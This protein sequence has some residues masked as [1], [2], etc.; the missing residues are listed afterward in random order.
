MSPLELLKTIYLGDRACKS[1]LIDGWNDRIVLQVDTIS[2]IRSVT[3]NWEYYTDEDIVDG[4]IVF[5]NA[6]SISF[7]PNGLM[8]NDL[9][10]SITAR[11]LPAK[12]NETQYYR[13]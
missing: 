3:G 9:I 12:S 8:P 6:T 7:E 13:F 5:T 11:V 1:L 2:R 4:L 10:H